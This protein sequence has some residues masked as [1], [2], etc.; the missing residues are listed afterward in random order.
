MTRQQANYQLVNLLHALVEKYPD[1]R[2]SQ[3][4]LAFEFII[5]KDDFYSEPQLIL[6]RV[7][8]KLKEIK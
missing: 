4:L 1:L 6:E 8:N 2:F 7:E 3:I 5:N